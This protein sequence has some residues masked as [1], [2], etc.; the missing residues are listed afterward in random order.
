MKSALELWDE[1]YRELAADFGDAQLAHTVMAAYRVPV[2]TAVE[3]NGHAASFNRETSDAGG[4]TFG[5]WQK[6]DGWWCESPLKGQAVSSC[7]VL[8][9][10]HAQL[11]VNGE[12]LLAA[13]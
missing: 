11:S 5:K 2:D 7:S 1:A 6:R 4:G 10:P 8:P 9:K 3:P 13:D 12:V